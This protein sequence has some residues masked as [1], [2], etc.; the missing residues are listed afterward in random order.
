MVN[1][2][3]ATIL[4]SFV[5]IDLYKIFAGKI[6]FY[7]FYRPLLLVI[8]YKY[9][10]ANVDVKLFYAALVYMLINYLYILRYLNKDEIK[11]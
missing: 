2:L 5:L 3:Y 9:I 1:I 6:N 4:I 11:K 8:T 10:L 7:N